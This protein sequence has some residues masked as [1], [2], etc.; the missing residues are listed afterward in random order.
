MPLLPTVALQKQGSDS[1]TVWEQ[2]QAAVV[3]NKKTLDNT[4]EETQLNIDS[5][6]SAQ[7]PTT[8]YNHITES[9]TR[10]VAKSFALIL[11]NCRKT[12]HQVDQCSN[13][14]DCAKASLDLTFCMGKIMCPLQH[15]A[16][17]RIIKQEGGELS[18]YN[19]SK[20][21]KDW[22]TQMDVTLENLATCIQLK[23]EQGVSARRLYP[24]LFSK[25]Q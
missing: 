24:S 6:S 9:Q 3:S 19:S 8:N 1:L 5:M 25:H 11:E 12:Q 2:I 15:E 17:T 22:D 16:V 21:T 23:S 20:N 13:D 7:L 10:D 18:G 4:K 14:T